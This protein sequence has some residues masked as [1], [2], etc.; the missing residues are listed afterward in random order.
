MYGLIQLRIVRYTRLMQ[1][2]TESIIPNVGDTWRADEIYLKVKGNMKYMFSMM[3][4]VEAVRE[5]LLKGTRRQN[6]SRGM[7]D[8]CWG[9]EQVE[10]FDRER[11][12]KT[13]GRFTVNRYN[14]NLLLAKW[15]FFQLFSFASKQFSAR[16]FLSRLRIWQEQL[17]LVLH[18]SKPS[19]THL[20]KR[21]TLQLK[22]SVVTLRILGLFLIPYFTIHPFVFSKH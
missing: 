3:D 18:N 21:C 17:L 11:K 20:L 19:P 4:D 10:N 9:K 2:C 15:F 1:N 6:T 7:R 12:P 13:I 16:V 8:N 5:F 14:V 22:V